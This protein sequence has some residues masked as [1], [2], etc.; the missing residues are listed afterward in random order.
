MHGLG[1]S[2][3]AYTMA[4]NQETT[5]GVRCARLIM[6]TFVVTKKKDRP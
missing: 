2:L 4:N 5:G 1:V 6:G 3:V